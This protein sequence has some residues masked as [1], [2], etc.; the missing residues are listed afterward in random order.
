MMA[1]DW[2]V[3]ICQPLHYTT[4][5]SP[6]LCRL[7]TGGLWV[8]SC[9]ISLTHILLMASL[10]FCHDK[11][12]PYYF[13]DLTPLLQISC[14]DASI[15]KIFGL[16]MAGMV[17]ATPFVCILTFYALIIVAIMKVSY[18]GGRKKAFS[19]CSYHHYVIA[20]FYGT[21]TRVCLCSSPVHSAVKEKASAV[22]YTSVTP[23]HLC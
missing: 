21:T 9:F 20:F 11:E 23:S 12:L 1:Y 19:S 13:C 3:V 6:C 14:T 2:F 22:I 16:I 8:F 17:I 5:M 4:I 10:V 15:N 7:L 18:A